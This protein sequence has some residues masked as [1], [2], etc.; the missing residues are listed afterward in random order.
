MNKELK[1]LSILSFK[2]PT[3]YLN[4]EVKASIKDLKPHDQQNR[5]FESIKV[6]G[7]APLMSRFNIVKCTFT[8]REGYIHTGRIF[9]YRSGYHSAILYAYKNGRSLNIHANVIRTKADVTILREIK[10]I[11]RVDQYLNFYPIYKA[12]YAENQYI[13]QA[14]S[15]FKH[16]LQLEQL[17]PPS[18]LQKYSLLAIAEAVST[19]HWPSAVT[20]KE[21]WHHKARAI[22]T[23]AV[24]ELLATILHNDQIADAKFMRGHRP[25]PPIQVDIVAWQ[26]LQKQLPFKLTESQQ[27]AVSELYRDFTRVRPMHRLLQGDVGCG[28]TIVFTAAILQV[29]LSNLTT[30]VL[31]PSTLLAQQHYKN[32]QTYFQSF[33]IPVFLVLGSRASKATKTILEEAADNPNAVIISTDF[34]WNDTIQSHTGLLIIDEQHKYGIQKRDNFIQQTRYEVN[35]LLI[36]ATPIPRTLMMSIYGSVELTNIRG[37]PASRKDITTY[38]FE[39]AKIPELCEKIKVPISRGEQVYWVCPRLGVNNNSKVKAVQ[40]TEDSSRQGSSLYESFH[41]LRQLLPDVTI[42][43]VHGKM[44]LED[45]DLTLTNFL[46]GKIHILMGTSVVEVGLDAPNATVMVIEDATY[47]GL[48]SLHQL[49]GRVGRRGKQSYCFLLYN[50]SRSDKGSPRSLERLQVLKKYQDGY[51][52]AQEDLSSRGPGHMLGVKQAGIPKFKFFTWERAQEIMPVAQALSEAITRDHP[53]I[54]VP[55]IDRWKL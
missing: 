25:I 34:I 11:H 24:E 7:Y 53:D 16:D 29:A 10:L 31:A 41:R 46:E 28:K 17:L 12:D 45:K 36:T 6:T 38:I 33:N 48:A 21:L 1:R 51:D 13:V 19:L 5:Y 9:S 47:F 32:L 52:I 30:C 18:L 8:D 43:Y 2:M 44:S 14:L 54:I 55:L 20:D 42:E 39:D 4:L 26:S 22:H 40:E 50:K 3:N 23:L 49:R 35:L 37:K 15:K 27:T